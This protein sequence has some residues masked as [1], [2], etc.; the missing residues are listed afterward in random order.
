[1]K[2]KDCAEAIDILDHAAEF[3]RKGYRDDDDVDE[4]VSIL[5]TKAEQIAE[6]FSC[7]HCGTPL[8]AYGSYCSSVCYKADQ[9]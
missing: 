7:N 8:D 3:L 9:L 1:M 2:A 5:E 4:A 6:G